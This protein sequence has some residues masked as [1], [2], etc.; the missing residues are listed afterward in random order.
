VGGVA[1]KL[2]WGT[3]SRDTPAQGEHD[4]PARRS[5]P[6]ASIEIG[7]VRAGV[8]EQPLIGINQAGP[9]MCKFAHKLRGNRRRHRRI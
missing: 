7:A 8:A 1:A 4:A 5:A 2:P 9:R 3:L 6:G